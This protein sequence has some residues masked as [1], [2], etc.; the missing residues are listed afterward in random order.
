[1]DPIQQL[2]ERQDLQ[3]PTVTPDRKLHTKASRE[4][5]RQRMSCQAQKTTCVLWVMNSSAVGAECLARGGTLEMKWNFFFSCLN[6]RESLANTKSLQGGLLEI[7]FTVNSLINAGVTS[8]QV[9]KHKAT[10]KWKIKRVKIS[11]LDHTLDQFNLTV[12]R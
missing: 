2:P 4:D 5:L 6:I 1:M 8:T 7:V 12:A 10:L 11:T 9:R 3:S